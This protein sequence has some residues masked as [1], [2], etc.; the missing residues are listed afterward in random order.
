MPPKATADRILGCLKC[1]M[2]VTGKESACPRCGKKFGKSSKFKCPFCGESVNGRSRKCPS[3]KAA[4]LVIPDEAE[5]E[6]V[7]KTVSE[8]PSDLDEVGPSHVKKEEK[9]TVCP[10]F[11][12]L[13]DGS[14]LMFS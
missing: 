14:E 1:G 12:W 3:C 8:V 9:R 5:A 13:L 10:N 2:R 6:S 7:D 11:S 4:L